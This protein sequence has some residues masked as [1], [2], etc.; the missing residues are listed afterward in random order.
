VYPANPIQRVAIQSRLLMSSSGTI[1]CSN[2][3]AGVP[4]L[5]GPLASIGVAFRTPFNL[6]R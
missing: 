1:V 4:M 2:I 6:V 3:A 5:V